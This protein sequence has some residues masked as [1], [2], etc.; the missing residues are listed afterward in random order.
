MSECYA[1][2]GYQ[3]HAKRYL[4]LTLCEDA[5]RANGEVSPNESGIY[6][7][8]VWGQGL[9]EEELCHAR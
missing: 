1:R 5:L 2:L 8:L 9:P 7:R 3:V 6:F 4:M